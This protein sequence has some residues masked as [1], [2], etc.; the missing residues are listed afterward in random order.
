MN[1]IWVLFLS[2]VV[3]LFAVDPDAAIIIDSTSCNVRDVVHA[4]TGQVFI[5]RTDAVVSGFEPIPISRMYVSENDS[6]LNWEGGWRAFPHTQFSLVLTDHGFVATVQEPDGMIGRYTLS[7]KDSNAYPE[8]DNSYAPPFQREISGRTD[9]RNNRIVFHPLKKQGCSG[10]TLHLGNGGQRIYKF[11]RNEHHPTQLIFLLEKEIRPNGNLITYDYGDSDRLK[12]ISTWNA[13]KTKQYASLTFRYVGE[14]TKNRDCTLTG[15]DG[16]SLHYH[17]WRPQDKHLHNFFYFDGVTGDGVIPERVSYHVGYEKNKDA[18]NKT[19]GPFP[20]KIYAGE[21]TPF[22]FSYY[23]PGHNQ[24]AFWDFFHIKNARDHVCDKVKDL[25]EPV[26]PN[27]SLIPTHSFLYQHCTDKGPGVTKVKDSLGNETHYHFDVHFKPSRIEFYTAGELVRTERF[28][29]EGRDLSWHIFQD[30]THTNSHAYH[31]QY[32]ERGNVKAHILYGNLTGMCTVPL[33]VNHLQNGIESYTTQ[34]DYSNDGFNLPIKK[35]EESGFKITYSYKPG[36]DLLVAKITYDQGKILSRRLYSYN[37]DNFLFEEVLDDGIFTE[38]TIVRYTPNADNF[39]AVIEELAFDLTFGEEVLLKKKVLHYNKRHQ[40]E[41]EDVYDSNNNYCYSTETDYKSGLIDSQTDPLNQKTTYKYTARHQLKEK[42]SPGSA[43]E[44]FKYDAAGRLTTKELVADEA[45]VTKFGY[46]DLHHKTSETDPFGATTQFDPD[47]FGSLKKITTTSDVERTATHKHDFLGREIERGEPNG[48]KT[49]IR[50]NAYGSPIYILRQ[51]G[52]EETFTYYK[53]GKVKTHIDPQKTVSS[54][55]YDVLG[56]LCKKEVHSSKNELLSS[57]EKGYDSFHLRTYTDPLGYTTTYEYDPAGRK[58]A[59]ERGESRT[60]YEYDALGKLHRTVQ[61]DLVRVV[62]RDFLDRTVEERKESLRGEIFYKKR[63]VHKDSGRTLEEISFPNNCEATTTHRFDLFGRETETVDPEGH[64]TR[65]DYTTT[66]RKKITTDALHRT[67]IETY[68]LLGKPAKLEKK[69]ARGGVIA[70]EEYFYDLNAN[71]SRQISSIYQS[72]QFLKTIETRWIYGPLNRL[73]QLI[74]ASSRT[75]SYTYTPTGLLYQT[76]KPSGKVLENTYDELGHLTELKSSDASVHYTFKPNALGWVLAAT[77]LNTGLTTTRQPDLDGN[78]LL[79]HLANDL[80]LEKTYDSSGRCKTLRFPDGSQVVKTY[81]PAYLREVTYS[82]LTHR[83]TQYDLAG[84]LLEEELPLQ[85]GTVQY[86]IDALSRTLSLS[87]PYHDQRIGSFDPVG[88]IE[89]LQTKLPNSSQSVQFGYDDLGQ[90]TED[91][92]HRYSYDSHYNRLAQDNSSLEVDD[93]N[94]LGTWEYDAD[95]NPRRSKD[96]T[97]SYDALDR[98]TVV[99]L[100]DHTKIT[101]IYDPFH[102]RLTKNLPDKTIR[103]LYDGNNEIG[104]EENGQLSIRVLGE[105]PQAEIGS[106]I[107]FRLSGSFQIPLHDLQ[108]NVALLFNQLAL[109]EYSY[110]PFGQKETSQSE[111][112]WRYLSKHTDTETG[113]VFFGRRYYD[114]TS[115]RFLTLD[116]KGYTDSQN[117]YAYALNGPFML[118][119]PYGLENEPAQNL[120]SNLGSL[121]S[122]TLGAFGSGIGNGFT[123]PIDTCGGLARDLSYLGNAA[124][125]GNLPTLTAA[126]KAMSLE[127]KLRFGAFHTSRVVGFGVAV[128]GLGGAFR[129]GCTALGS[130]YAGGRAML[131][132]GRALLPQ[133][134]KTTIPETSPVVS[135]AVKHWNPL[136]GPGPLALRDALSFRSATYTAHFLQEPT[137]LHRSYSDSAKAL[138]SYWSRTKPS[139]PLQSTMDNALKSSWGN[140][141]THTLTIK[142]PPGTL[143]YEG[144]VAPQ[145]GLLGGGNQIFLED[146]N[147]LW[148]IK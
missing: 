89:S 147:P 139:G 43:A 30:P 69:D 31:Y 103:Y 118:V 4:L 37:E 28:I 9:V 3:H 81:D 20:D 106:A 93:L 36:T 70:Q 105:T 56:R 88:K 59:E 48:D 1:K 82:G 23:Y 120:S 64:V 58:I 10:A 130:V 73:S 146:I 71:L 40:V 113:F 128:S 87:S 86:Q 35:E 122:S 77:D 61:E 11:V 124:W 92:E 114:P 8:L 97:L 99:E 19:R 6:A 140:R 15:S 85:T 5:R 47:R 60:E 84:N 96:M 100:P 41:K 135:A 2:L 65:F 121:T 83:Y 123:H 38:R 117:L 54:Y 17:F 126:W 34:Y 91:G 55:R 143:V 142:A 141:A 102:R 95:G 76:I 98:L 110:S 75:T 111:N 45:L 27:G 44:I 50:Y 78:I 136:N 138:G 22:Q 14:K 104:F 129:L 144:V 112:P 57:E 51:D 115:G 80:A 24:P 116:P 145:G 79:E 33:D 18:I 109:E 72:T 108:G 29:W 137:I 101:Y 26:G 39:P 74:E 49:V 13:Q 42:C 127:E 16:T 53:N 21:D 94:Q 25:K 62:E 131:Q 134:G 67:K 132:V 66:P 63:F 90:L 68:N 12:T 52:S 7:A 107:I 119:D 125:N 32:D 148:V 133:I 46:N